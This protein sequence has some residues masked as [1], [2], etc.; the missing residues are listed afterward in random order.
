MREELGNDEKDMEAGRPPNRFYR[1]NH[2]EPRPMH[3]DLVKPEAQRKDGRCG[4]FGMKDGLVVLVKEA[5]LIARK[6]RTLTHP[7]NDH[8]SVV[9]RLEAFF[10][11]R[12][13]RNILAALSDE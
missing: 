3:V 4:E 11:F 5:L 7:R 2:R 1:I 10:G 13:R 8:P 9:R 12:R 6:I